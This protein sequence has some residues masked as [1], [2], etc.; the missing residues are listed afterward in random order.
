MYHSTASHGIKYLS[1][2][3]THPSLY[4]ITLSI[5][6]NSSLIFDL[7]KVSFVSVTH[8]HVGTCAMESC[9]NTPSEGGGG[10][11]PMSPLSPK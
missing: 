10:S 7:Q 1:C 3:I 5:T 6:F 9:L 8:V 11:C 2:I 4:Y